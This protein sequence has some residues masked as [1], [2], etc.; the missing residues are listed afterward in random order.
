MLASFAC[1]AFST[2]RMETLGADE[3]EA[4]IQDFRSATHW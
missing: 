3:L 4:R 1:E 2:R